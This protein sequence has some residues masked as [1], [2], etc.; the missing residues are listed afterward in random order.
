MNIGDQNYENRGDFPGKGSKQESKPG[1]ISETHLRYLNN[2][3]L[4]RNGNDVQII[5]LSLN[6]KL[7]C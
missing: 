5:F 2:L 3:A 6:L 4:N 7:S 1:S